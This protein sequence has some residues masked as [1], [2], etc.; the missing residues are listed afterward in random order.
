MG[1]RII[2]LCHV[3]NATARDFGRYGKCDDVLSV[4]ETTYGKKAAGHHLTSM[5]QGLRRDVGL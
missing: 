5:N 2:F 1:Q 3:E 4:Q